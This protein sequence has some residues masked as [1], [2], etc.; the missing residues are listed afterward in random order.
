MYV[1][2]TKYKTVVEDTLKSLSHVGHLLP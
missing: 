1:Y 2:V